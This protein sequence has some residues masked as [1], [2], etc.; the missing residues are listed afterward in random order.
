MANAFSERVA[1]LN[2]QAG[3]TYQ[4]MA[5][6]C[7]FKRSVTWWNKVRWNEIENPPE[8]GLFPYLA[9]ALEVPQRRVAEMVAEQWCGVRPDDTVPE[10]LRTLLSVL[11]EVDEADLSV[12][13]EMAMSMFRKRT[14][15][16]ERDQLSAELLMA[17]IEGSEGPLT[18]EQV[19]K[20]RLPEQYAIK[21]DP[22]VEVAPD[23]Q[24][25]LDALPD[26][27]EE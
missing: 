8:P 11:R 25:M 4:E 27:E 26:L 21:N 13:I 9:K 6:D 3:K 15:R 16:M 20:L 1:R 23:A 10:R 5:H 14:I 24:A 12:M 2:T 17:Y 22:S 7:D 19:R 18:W